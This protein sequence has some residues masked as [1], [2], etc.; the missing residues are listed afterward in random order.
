MLKNTKIFSLLCL[1]ILPCNNV[2]ACITRGKPSPIISQDTEF[3]F[4]EDNRL[5]LAEENYLTIR[6]DLETYFDL[7]LPDYGEFTQNFSDIVYGLNTT[8]L[9]LPLD[10]PIL[11]CLQAL[12]QI[13]DTY[14]YYVIDIPFELDFGMKYTHALY[15]IKQ[16]YMNL[17]RAEISSADYQRDL[18][19]IFKLTEEYLLIDLSIP[20][21]NTK[22]I[23]PAIEALIDFLQNDM[24]Q[25]DERKIKFFTEQLLTTTFCAIED[26]L[27]Q[28]LKEK[29]LQTL[30]L[31]TPPKKPEDYESIS[32]AT[33][34]SLRGKCLLLPKIPDTQEQKDI[35]CLFFK[36]LLETLQDRGI[37]DNDMLHRIAYLTNRAIT[38]RA[39]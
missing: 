25:R 23:T 26:H 37:L 27:F 3:G 30:C 2:K 35:N 10:A 20:T 34:R 19:L 12:E 17:S 6:H 32:E 5:I 18:R 16:L 38:R 1:I 11:R 9:T 22:Q 29:D 15:E 39:N 24:S 4:Q 7:Q 13:N 31:K 14:R 33:E 28:F 36:Q 8:F 21:L